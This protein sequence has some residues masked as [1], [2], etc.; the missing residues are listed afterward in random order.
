MREIEK[1][2]NAIAEDILYQIEN[3][4]NFVNSYLNILNNK[5]NEDKIKQKIENLLKK[6]KVNIP[7]EE[8][9]NIKD[10]PEK[11]K[12]FIEKNNK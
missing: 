11:I 7:M 5:N 10:N 9:L 8:L 6:Y 3:T 12:K 4:L 2:I 1:L